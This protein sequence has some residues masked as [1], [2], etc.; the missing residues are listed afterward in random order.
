MVTDILSVSDIPFT[1]RIT[2][3]GMPEGMPATL[4]VLKNILVIYATHHHVK[5]TSA[6]FLSRLPCHKYN[7]SML[8]VSI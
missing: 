2:P 7:S 8:I 3:S 6:R 1:L 5:Y 4:H